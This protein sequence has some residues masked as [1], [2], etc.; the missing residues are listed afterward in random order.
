[1]GKECDDRRKEC[2]L[3]RERKEEKAF[4]KKDG[5]PEGNKKK[6]NSKRVI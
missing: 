5:G 3:R 4:R 1:M 2:E 6:E